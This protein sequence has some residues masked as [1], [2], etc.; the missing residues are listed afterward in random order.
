MF[1]SGS[2]SAVREGRNIWQVVGGVAGRWGWQ[3][4]EVKRFAT[5]ISSSATQLRS[6]LR[7]ALA[8]LLG[9]SRSGPVTCIALLSGQAT[10]DLNPFSS[11]RVV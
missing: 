7:K 9:A 4:I 8:R 5:E 11:T 3:A 1:V 2:N 6:Q 10:L